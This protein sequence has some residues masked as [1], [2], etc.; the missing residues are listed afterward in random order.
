MSIKGEYMM[1]QIYKLKEFKLFVCYRE[2]IVYHYDESYLSPKI[3]SFFVEL[4]KKMNK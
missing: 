2:L 1:K 3:M 4:L